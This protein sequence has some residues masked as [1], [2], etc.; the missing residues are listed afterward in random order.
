MAKPS[1]LDFFPKYNKSFFGRIFEPSGVLWGLSA[2]CFF[3]FAL[4]LYESAQFVVILSSE[5]SHGPDDV[6]SGKSTLGGLFSTEEN[7][8]GLSWLIFWQQN[9]K[10]HTHTRRTF[11][12]LLTAQKCVLRALSSSTL[13]GVAGSF[14]KHHLGGHFKWQ[15]CRT[16]LPSLVAD[17]FTECGGSSWGHFQSEWWCV[18]E[19]AFI[20]RCTVRRARST[21]LL[22]E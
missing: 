17:S 19:D 9:K 8:S 6:H 21:E 16:L 22:G 5:K 4:T 1:K 13:W 15:F 10:K 14:F 20:T 11:A 12:V 18:S 2:V 7:Y 3:Y